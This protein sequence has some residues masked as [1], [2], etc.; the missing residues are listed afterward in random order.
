[1]S[2]NSSRI[3]KARS[4]DRD[5]SSGGCAFVA[6]RRPAKGPQV[7]RSKA[8]S[9]LPLTGSGTPTQLRRTS[10]ELMV[11]WS[12]TEE[13]QHS[14]ASTY[15][16]LSPNRRSALPTSPVRRRY[17]KIR[18]SRVAKTNQPPANRARFTWCQNMLRSKAPSTPANIPMI[19]T[20]EI[21]KPCMHYSQSA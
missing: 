8:R 17:G 21:E 19:I 3:C 20:S 6:Q 1:M 14:R 7:R 13:D 9:N 4:P 16:A 18:H 10:P 12:P 15:R 5:F 2:R 11:R